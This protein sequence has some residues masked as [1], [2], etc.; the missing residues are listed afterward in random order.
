MARAFPRPYLGTHIDGVH[1]DAEQLL[2]REHNLNELLGTCTYTD[3]LFHILQGRLPSEQE[4]QLFDLVLV[5]FH[6]GFGLLPPT[7][8]VPRLVAGTGV[9]TAQALAAGYLASGP[10]HVGAVEHAMGL[11]HDVLKGFR[12]QHAGDSHTAGELAQFAWDWAAG[13]IERRETVPGYG[14]PLLRK[15]PRP[16]HVR[17]LLCD[18]DAHSPYLDI[19]DGVVGCMLEKKGVSPNV[20]GI[21]GAILMTLGF[22]PAHGTGLFLLARTAAM[23][24]HVVEEQS[25]MPYLTQQRLTFLPVVAPRIFNWNFKRVTKFF[26]RLRDNR[27]YRVM[28][29]RAKK[30]YRKKE[31]QD[32]AVIDTAREQRDAE[33]LPAVPAEAEEQRP[34]DE[35]AV[36]ADLREGAEHV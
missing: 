7:T 27:V 3:A 10:Y 24:A 15:D 13:L 12:E 6:G 9:S 19:Y 4:R 36:Q 5:A 11:Y 16:T 32:Q 26:N 18:M 33:T 25:D 2:V 14:H 20:D 30:P 28:T 31:E 35:F 29:D 1:L 21:T 8:L 17:R 22:T 34:T 23:L